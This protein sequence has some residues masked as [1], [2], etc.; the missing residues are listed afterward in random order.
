MSDEAPPLP[1]VFMSVL[2]VDEAARILADIERHAELL[3]VTL[4]SAARALAAEPQADLEA[5]HCFLAGDDHRSVQL[6]YR[7]GG[8]VWS[9]TLMRLPSGKLKLVRMA[10]A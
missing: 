8:R 3:A 2:E 9:D 7:F 5:A 1:D 10:D 4:K 6:R